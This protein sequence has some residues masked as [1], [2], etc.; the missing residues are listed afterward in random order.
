ME[1]LNYM[2]TMKLITKLKNFKH[3]KTTATEGREEGGGKAKEVA[4]GCERWKM[5]LLSR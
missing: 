1:M 4:G 5:T 2:Q 3:D